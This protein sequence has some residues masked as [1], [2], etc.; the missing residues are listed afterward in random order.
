MKR[1]V[2]IISLCALLPIGGAAAQPSTGADV[3]L[4]PSGP[5]YAEPVGNGADIM[6]QNLILANRGRDPVEIVTLEVEFTGSGESRST[7]RIAIP[8]LV[9]NSRELAGMAAQGMGPLVGAQ[10][11]DSRGAAA[12][13]GENAR[14][15]TDARLETGELL[16]GTARYY[17]LPFVPET[18]RIA[19][20]YRAADGGER[21]ATVVSPVAVRPA[22][23]GYTLPL[24][25]IWNMRGLAGARSHH[26]RIPSNEFAVDFFRLGTDG[27]I[28]AGDNLVAT[29][30]F[31]YGAP[32]LAAADGTVVAVNADET[33]DRTVYGLR[34]GETR[35]TAGRRIQ[36]YRM[37]RMAEDF[38]GALAGN[39]IT[40]R[41]EFPDGRVEYSNYG[42]LAA[43]SVRVAVGDRVTRGQEIARVGDTGDSSV[44]HLHFQLNAGPDP[45]FSRSLPVRFDN[46][47]ETFGGQDA[48]IFVTSTD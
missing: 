42:H 41:H 13:G 45:F 8:T 29:N 22:R 40:I 2:A 7:H 4:V 15:S 1:I 24:A 46:M 36:Q 31:G 5:L 47:R 34:E 33:Q 20:T 28:S 19:A 18:I 35:E 17:A 32:V 38:R 23:L 27:A 6:L 26:R 16:A 30:S 11:L 44:V 9:N 48:G 12:F 21:M 43:G 3:L 14:L 37:A 10:L 39:L 25:G